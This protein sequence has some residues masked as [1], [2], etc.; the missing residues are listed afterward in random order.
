MF[1]INR[2]RASVLTAACLMVAAP[3]VSTPAWA[4]LD[5]KF[6]LDWKF[7]GPTAAFLVAAD[8]GYYAEEGLDVS[9]DSGNGSAGAVTRVAS[10]AYQMGFA[11]INALVDFNAQNSGQSVKAVMMAY[12]AP[13]FSLFTLAKNNIK[14]PA[15]L[16]GR[17]LGAPVF[18]ASYKLFPAFAHETGIDEKAVERVNMSP[19]LRETM[20]VQGEVDFISGHYFS[21]M[22][23]LKA[24]GVAEKDIKYFLY[25]D[26][27]MDFYGNA[28]IASGNFISDHPEA[29][30]GF[31]RATVRGWKDIIA[32]PQGAIEI[33]AKS[34]PLIDKK[35]EL[36]RLQLAL[37]VN[38]LTPHVLKAGIG[39]VDEARLKNSIAQLA[40]AYG[41]TATPEP[42]AVWTSKFLPPAEERMLSR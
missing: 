24:K 37:D 27:G 41:L 36:E 9:I 8:K 5:I 17:K 40:L 14:T 33:V 30:S 2:L 38:V 21:S 19:A 28:V 1:K 25:A 34:D 26:F 10:G 3:M 13:P 31:I 42:S 11:D 6:T 39:D 16:A 23:D 35:L 32:D 29:V 7:Q 20:L 4:E 12:D 15:D 22:L 18:D